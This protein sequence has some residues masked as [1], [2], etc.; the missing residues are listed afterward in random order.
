ML[1]LSGLRS[2]HILLDD[3]PELNIVITVQDLIKKKQVDN[4]TIRHLS[5]TAIS[6]M[7]NI[8][9]RCCHKVLMSG[10]FLILEMIFDDPV[11]L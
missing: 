9:S 4:Q 3:K 10:L 2:N 11:S 7:L 6:E 5:S 8:V 1:F